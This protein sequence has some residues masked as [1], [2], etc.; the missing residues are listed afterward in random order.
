MIS[1]L[2]YSIIF[3]YYDGGKDGKERVSINADTNTIRDV[4]MISD[5]TQ[6]PDGDE[7]LQKIQVQATTTHHG[8]SSFEPR[9]SMGRRPG[10]H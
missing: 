5:V 10:L 8:H 4:I 1:I 9:L 7:P 2:I 6:L 3:I